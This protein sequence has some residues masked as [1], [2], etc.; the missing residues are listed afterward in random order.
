MNL[1]KLATKSTITIFLTELL[2]LSQNVDAIRF[3]IDDH[4]VSGDNG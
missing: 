4:Q 2:V 1:H 3:L